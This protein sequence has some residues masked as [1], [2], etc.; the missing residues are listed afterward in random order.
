LLDSDIRA[1]SSEVHAS[2]FS[3]LLPF[4]IRTSSSTK[5]SFGITRTLQKKKVTRSWHARERLSSPGPPSPFQRIRRARWTRPTPLDHPVPPE[6][7]SDPVELAPPPPRAPS[8]SRRPALLPLHPRLHARRG[9]A[10]TPAGS[11]TCRCDPSRPRAC[12]T[13]K[14]NARISRTPRSNEQFPLRRPL[15]PPLSS[16]ATR[17]TNASPPTTA[18]TKITVST[19]TAALSSKSHPPSPPEGRVSP[20]HRSPLPSP[21]AHSPPPRPEISPASQ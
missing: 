3:L 11:P 10:P 15:P 5:A 8:P 14:A 21:S 6:Q 16:T 9:H 12:S 7:T 2:Q 13:V 19:P 17:H 4:S 18:T 1:H 20:P